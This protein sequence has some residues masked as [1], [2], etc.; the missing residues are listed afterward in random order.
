VGRL[1]EHGAAGWVIV[2]QDLTEFRRMEEAVRRSDRLAVVGGLA[3]GLAHEIRNPLAAMC[4]SVELLGGSPGLVESERQLLQIVQSEGKRL[5]ALV[6]DFLSFAKPASPE[7]GTVD[8]HDLVVETAE[9][10]RAETE[11]RGVA[12]A[13]D[14]E[15]GIALLADGPQMKQVLWNLLGNAADATSAGGSITVVFRRRGKEALLSVTDSGAG[16]AR[17]D[18]PRI[19]DP[20]FTTKER[21]TGLG[22]AIVHRVVEAHGGRIAVQSEPGKGS[23]FSVSLPAAAPQRLVA[24]G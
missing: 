13:V 5:E 1:N 14:A 21:G 22:L 17:E 7:I 11:R 18:L 24:A 9:L 16:I 23:T 12:L 6:R 3:A 2:F 4:G 8:G 10:F 15:A 19:F 20:F